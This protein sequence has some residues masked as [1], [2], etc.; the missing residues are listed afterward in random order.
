MD[1][2]VLLEISL[3]A[4]TEIFPCAYRVSP[5]GPPQISDEFPL[6]F[7]VHRLSVAGILPADRE[8]PQ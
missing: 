5:F 8:F 1:D 6:H 7:I 3:V 4:E 2:A